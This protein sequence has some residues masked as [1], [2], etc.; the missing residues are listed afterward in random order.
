M[1]NLIPAQ[2]NEVA[3]AVIETSTVFAMQKSQYETQVELAKRFPR[4]T[5]RVLAEVEQQACFS[6]EQ[7]ARMNY[8]VPR[9]GKKLTG[10][11]VRL[12]EIFASN[13]GNLHVTIIPVG[14]EG[15]HV[16]VRAVVWD[17]EKNFQAEIQEQKSVMGKNGQLYSPDMID[18]TMRSL[19]SI[20]YRN[21]IFRAIPKAY[22]DAIYQKCLKTATGGEMTLQERRHK[23]LEY[24]WDAHKIDETRL[25]KAVNKSAL[26]ML[27]LE[28]V[29]NLKS[30]LVAIRDGEMDINEVFPDE[31]AT[32]K[33]EKKNSSTADTV[34]DQVKGRKTKNSQEKEEQPVTEAEISEPE[35]TSEQVAEVVTEQPET[36]TDQNQGDFPL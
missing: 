35:P 22:I 19:S 23:L 18:T 14:L 30:M 6:A 33:T 3:T 11:S 36:E 20:A 1:S 4:N 24:A 29:A 34:K 17:L 27:T 28:D 25:C 21:A 12:A 9:A 32:E 26:L 15:S 10:P 2:S 31:S 5:S 7:A 13:W 8:A 16:V